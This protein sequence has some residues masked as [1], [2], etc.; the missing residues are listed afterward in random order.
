MATENVSTGSYEE[1]LQRIL[2]EERGKKIAYQVKMV[3]S[4]IGLLLILVLIFSGL[5]INLGFTQINFIALD[6]GFIQENIRFIAEGALQTILISI[7]SIA[8][9][10]ILAFLSAIARLSKNAPAVALSTFYVSLIRGTPLYLQVIFFFLALPQMGIYFSGFWAGVIALSLNYGAYMSEIFRAGI[11]SV[12]K[13]QHEAATALG[14]SPGQK[15]RYIV[16]P[17]ALRLAIPPIGNEY[18][19]MLKD[20]ALVSVTGFVREIL[21]RAQRV[22]RA[23]FKNLEALVIA[24]LFYWILTLIFTAIQARVEARFQNGEGEI[25][26]ISH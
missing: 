22:G 4:W 10:M 12:S 23:S 19:A 14:M 15:M 16:L 26:Q 9:A 13:G 25:K 5:E 17:Q 20:S 3:L 2:A 8:L 18:I 1:D 24:A 6:T 21:W 7:A 11:L